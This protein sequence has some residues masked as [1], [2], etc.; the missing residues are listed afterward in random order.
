MV[1]S[2]SLAGKVA[3]VTG[4]SS[5]I[6]RALARALIREGGKVVL[7]GRSL[8]RLSALENELGPDSLAFPL[9]LASGA[10][11]TGMVERT[12]AHFG[13]VDILIANAGLFMTGAFTNADPDEWSR[14]IAVNIDA[15]FRS[16][17]A[18]LPT[19]RA[20]KSGDILVMSSIAGVSEMRN[21]PIYAASKHAVQ[22][23][24]HSLRRQVADDGIRVGAIQ[25]GTVATELWGPVDPAAVAARVA[26]RTVLTP[27]DVATAAIFILS[28]PPNV[29][30]RDLVILPQRQ[31]I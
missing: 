29:T 24:V 25:P 28:Q 12:V 17:H 22:A 6:G 16:A 2:N 13:A 27:E 3:I 8:D 1:M 7:A 10:E 23:F 15:V 30:I 14:L 20:R 5:G 31:D 19:M 4:A 26:E 21:E 11:I 9:D 18:V